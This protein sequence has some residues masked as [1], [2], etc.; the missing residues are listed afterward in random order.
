MDAVLESLW[1]KSGPHAG[2]PLLRHLLDVAAVAHEVVHRLPD[3]AIRRFARTTGV[4]ETDSI[5]CAALLVGCHDLGKASPG[6]QSKWEPGWHTA[7]AQGFEGSTMLPRHDVSTQPILSGLLHERGA[8]PEGA[9]WLSCAVAAHHGFFP[10]EV[11]LEQYR[12]GVA[13]LN[14][15]W[16]AAHR[17]LFDAIHA[18]LDRPALPHKWD[19]GDAGPLLEW[20]AGLTSVC[21]WIGSAEAYFSR[22]RI[23]ASYP[24]H[25]EQAKQLAKRTLDA[26]H[27]PSGSVLGAH[28]SSE[29]LPILLGGHQ[30]RPLQS[31]IV[32]LAGEQKDPV[33][34]IVEAP[35]G[36]GKTEAALWLALSQISGGGRGL[37]FALPT[38]ATANGLYPRI[39]TFLA[40]GLLVPDLVPQLV[41]GGLR[42]L[43]A[44]G[45][46][47]ADGRDEGALW[48][49]ARRRG[50]VAPF[51]VGTVDQALMGVLNAKHRFVRLFGLA[52]RTV[53]LDEV[54]AYDGYTS[55][56]I[57]SLVQWLA[58]LDCSVVLLS[59]TLPE[60]QHRRLVQAWS[61]GSA[62]ELPVPAYP[63][64]TLVERSGR[65][66]QRVA[67][68]SRRCTYRLRQHGADVAEIGQAALG[69]A[70]EGRCVLV[71]CNTVARAQEVYRALPGTAERRALFHARFP[72]DQR[73]SIEQRILS[74]FGPGADRPDGF[75]LV[76]TQVVEQSLD[77]DFDVL[78][79]DACPIDL[80]FQRVG[81]VWRHPRSHR[82][83]AGPEVY[84]AGLGGD[85]VR[86]AHDVASVYLQELVL[87]THVCLAGRDRL[88]VPDDIDPLV[89]QVYGE[90]FEWPAE[91]AEAGLDASK[92]RR[93]LAARHDAL[94]QV[95]ALPAPDEWWMAQPTQR[96]D[97]EQAEVA[98][99]LGQ[100]SL[101]VAPLYLDGTH[102]SAIP[103]GMRWLSDNR[104]PEWAVARLA[105][106]TLRLSRPDVVR[107]LREASDPLGWD[108]APM[109]KG[110][111]PMVLD[112][113]GRLVKDPELVRLDAE[114]GLIYG[115]RS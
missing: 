88:T 115:R 38:Q 55:G 57:A 50:L 36:E 22:D 66:S 53:V 12:N 76:A 33:L 62:R 83:A 44:P 109:L 90:S 96:M 58:A 103:G 67:A 77:I 87:R 52:D 27:W 73:A 93:D 37:Y 82:P 32:E 70:G 31:A 29:W 17:N 60:R 72:G 45:G 1:A 18:A 47:Y 81:R 97:D 42:P 46:I 75:I 99:R 91:L 19:D 13:A 28:E 65:S 23:S 26:L 80:L 54:H 7:L 85:A 111:V 43:L 114:L 39:S 59:A 105:T 20:I 63:R 6:F 14:R 25:F 11:Q 49:A 40:S 106:R 74:A 56:L 15:Q 101:T 95:A 3:R 112:S 41:H 16:Q 2:Y 89:Q 34:L 61:G 9:H 30:P 5:R 21:D 10:D 79:T 69:L 48:F 71:V 78:I 68:A 98:T 4:S 113:D 51:G 64:I 100:P 102:L 94:V 104:V 84:V 108:D 8:H 35:P 92:R 86:V 107:L 24:A 110:V